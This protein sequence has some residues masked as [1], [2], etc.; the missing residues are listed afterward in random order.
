MKVLVACE[1]SGTVREAFRCRGHNAWSCD[2]L[3]ADDNSDFH[4]Q[5]NGI[6]AIKSQDWDLIICHPPY[7]QPDQIIQPW[8]FGHP[9]QK[10]TCLWLS[11]LP[12][13]A[14][15]ND[16]YSEMM[17]LPDNER[18]RLHYLPPGPDRWKIR[19]KTFEGIASAMA[20][21]WCIDEYIDHPKDQYSL[22]QSL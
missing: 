3:P 20:E 19:S 7:R 5:G 2:L 4:I 11:K 21:Q 17:E 6:D 12:P 18:Q 10:A 22:F 16:V 9:E 1:S 14:S 8:M 13:L 15:T